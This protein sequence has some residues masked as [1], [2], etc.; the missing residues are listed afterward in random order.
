MFSFKKLNDLFSNG[1]LK[2]NIDAKRYVNKFF[3]PLTNGEHAL[4]QEDNVTIIPKDTM[5]DVYL[6]RFPDDIKKWYKKSTI[7]KKLICD[8]KQPQ[9]GK[10]FI[11][12]AP[13]LLKETKPFNTFH[14]K[15]QAGVQKM[16]KFLKE[17]WCENSN[18][19]LQFLLFWFAD[20][21]KGK[22]NKSII[23]VKSIEGV[24]KSTFI[25]FFVPIEVTSLEWDNTQP[26]SSVMKW[27]YNSDVYAVID[28]LLVI[29]DTS[30]GIFSSVFVP[31]HNAVP[32]ES[33]IHNQDGRYNYTF[34]LSALNTETKS[35]NNGSDS[36]KVMAFA[37][38]AD[39]ISPMS[40]IAS[41][42]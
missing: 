30:T 3:C 24:G 16:L 42:R 31:A 11:N 32:D 39:G 28:F 4:I 5:Q 15:S 41:V 37:R 25:D 40:N 29:M 22:K 10:D 23:Y 27:H 9:I 2:E 34:A 12:T 17:V 19:Q 26:N 21:L 8:V 33:I 1:P 18:I 6:Q 35:M 14:E 38:N 20:V 36:M 7:P 13:R